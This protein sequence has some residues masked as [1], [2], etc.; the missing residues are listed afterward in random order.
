MTVSVALIQVGVTDDEPV[1]ER[2]TRVIALTRE[3]AADHD[4]VVLPELWQIGAFSVDLVPLSAESLGGPLSQAL[5]GVAAAGRAW[6]FAGSVPERLLVPGGGVQHFNTQL[7]FGPDGTLRGAYRK[8]HLFG[9]NGGETTVMTS[10]SDEVV[11]DCPLG[12]T[13]LA[14]CYDLRFPELF[15]TLVDAGAGAF[16][17]PAGWPERRKSHWVVLARARAIENQ[18]FVL[19]CNLVGTHAGVPMAGRSM[20]IDPQGEVLA[21]A[22]AAEEVLVAA[23]DPARIDAWR[24][25]FPALED[26]RMGDRTLA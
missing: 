10:G 5:G 25:A 9:F 6:L 17:I 20:V 13:G 23:V 16:V 19:A 1:A 14:T 26:R 8:I 11:V 21:E 2:I 12:P 7:V 24:T 18:A 15:R 3:V 22:G 4:V